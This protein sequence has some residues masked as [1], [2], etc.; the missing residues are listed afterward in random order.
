MT[1][2][3]SPIIF[4]QK[5]VNTKL[6]AIELFALYSKPTVLQFYIVKFLNFIMLFS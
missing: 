5:R 1:I 6:L 2:K 3:G 4:L